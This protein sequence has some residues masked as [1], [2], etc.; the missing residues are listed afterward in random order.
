MSTPPLDGVRG[1]STRRTQKPSTQRETATTPAENS[2]PRPQCLTL[3]RVAT[4]M[5]AQAAP[6][7]VAVMVMMAMV[8]I[9]ATAAAV[10]T[11][12]M[13]SQS[14]VPTDGNVPNAVTTAVAAVA[15]V[16][17][18]MTKQAIKSAVPRAVSASS[19]SR[20]TCSSAGRRDH[21]AH[22]DSAVRVLRVHRELL[23]R[24]G[25]K[26]LLA[27]KDRKV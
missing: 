27:H 8:M 14:P 16:A 17:A 4:I 9:A 18:T 15:A 12:P 5:V 23:E 3:P 10:I 22:R 25:H 13:T 24:V 7:P 26:V 19:A 1:R 21:K 20:P 11:A 2:P 6:R